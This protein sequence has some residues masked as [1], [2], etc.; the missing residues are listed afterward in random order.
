M[1]ETTPTDRPL[2][3]QVR[4]EIVDEV[5]W[6]TIDRPEKGNALSPPCRNRIRDLI[7]GLN[8]AHTA[9]AIV[10]TASGEKLFCPG[11]DLS[12]RVPSERP[13]GVPERVVGDARR[14]MLEG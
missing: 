13:E 1:S 9:R 7:N 3:E 2:D 11:A 14:M 5:A 12:H 6:I 4:F 10:L 8:G